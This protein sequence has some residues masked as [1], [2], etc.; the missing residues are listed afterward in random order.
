MRNRTE[1]A[2][3]ASLLLKNHL[4]IIQSKY[5]SCIISCGLHSWYSIYKKKIH[6]QWTC[7]PQIVNKYM[8]SSLMYLDRSQ[9]CIGYHCD[10]SRGP[11]IRRIIIKLLQLIG[12]RPSEWIKSTHPPNQL[13]L[14][15]FWPLS[16]APRLPK[17]LSK[18]INNP[19]MPTKMTTAQLMNFQ[20]SSSLFVPVLLASPSSYKKLELV[21][22][23]VRN[24][25]SLAAVF[26][27]NR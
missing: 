10:E 2:T 23:T 16:L 26:W 18:P 9:D 3:N 27:K 21:I 4:R 24:F 22:Q 13:P 15:S 25:Q 20:P 11:A 19:K 17:M 12:S 8:G 14:S 7:A 5:S 1:R 6:K